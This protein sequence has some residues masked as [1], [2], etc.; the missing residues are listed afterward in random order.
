MKQ[1]KEY[2]G[3]KLKAKLS[4]NDGFAETPI[5]S[6]KASTNEKEKGLFM[7][8]LICQ[9]FNLSIR[10]YIEYIERDTK[11]MVEE[12]NGLNNTD[13]TNKPLHR[14]EWGN[15][16]SPFTSKRKLI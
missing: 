16:A 7:I 15:L 6:I 14:D 3:N 13:S 5:Y 2:R 1:R 8:N 12:I 10:N 11:A 9:N 4:F